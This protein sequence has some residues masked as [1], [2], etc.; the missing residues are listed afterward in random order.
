MRIFKLITTTLD[1]INSHEI[2]N[3]DRENLI[4]NKLKER[5]V[6]CCYNASLILDISKIMRI[7]AIRMAARLDG[8]ASVDVQFEA[9]C[10][11]LTHGELT[12]CKVLGLH[13]NGMTA[14]ND[15]STIFVR[16]EKDYSAAYK[17]IQIGDVIPVIIKRVAYNVGRNKISAIAHIYM[18]EIKPN[19][20]YEIMSG[21]E[22][23]EID[24]I[25]QLYENVK[26]IKKKISQKDKNIVVLFKAFLYPYKKN[27]DF[28]ESKMHKYELEVKNM[29]EINSGVV[30]YPSETNKDKE[31]FY[32]S[33]ISRE[34][35]VQSTAYAA[36]SNIINVYINHLNSILTLCENY[37]TL[38]DIRAINSYWLVCNANKY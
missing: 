15:F 8:G 4:K 33:D 35:A 1:L 38:E 2:Y 29:A 27:A 10:L 26:D 13:N 12:C 36:F 18:P 22:D 23:G 19:I 14:I 30:V 32:Y 37:P 11:V 28:T 3:P 17:T 16:N 6:N 34:N 7:S 21:L 31:L 20:Y 24:K 25:N 5:Y 9:E